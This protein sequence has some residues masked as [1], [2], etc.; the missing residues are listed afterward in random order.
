MMAWHKQKHY[1]D[2]K[3][4]ERNFESGDMVFLVLPTDH[5]KL[6]LNWKGPFAVKA[7]EGNDYI[8]LVGGRERTSHAYVRRIILF[9]AWKVTFN[10]KITDI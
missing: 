2:K 9:I 1:C 10:P 7:R 5:R 4:G 6:L 8:I 3:S